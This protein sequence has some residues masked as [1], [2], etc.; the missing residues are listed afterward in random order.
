MTHCSGLGTSYEEAL[1]R[2]YAAADT[3]KASRTA[4]ERS[5]TIALEEAVGRV[6]ACDILSPTSTPEHDTSAMDGYAIRSDA[7]KGASHD[8]P[9]ILR[10]WGTIAAGDDPN[11]VLGGGDADSEQFASTVEPCLEIMTGARFPSRGV[12]KV[13]DACVRME[14]VVRIEGKTI[15]GWTVPTRGTYIAITKPVL[16]KAN[17]RI[18]GEDIRRHGLILK[19]G[20]TI[21]SSHLLP[22]A[23]VGL[24][25]LPV[26]PKPQVCV[27]STG[28][29]LGSGPVCIPDVNGLYLSAA[30]REHG[31][32]AGFLGVLQDDVDAVA[33]TIMRTA[34]NRAA[35]ILITSGGVSVGKF[36][37]IRKALDRIGADIIF[38]GLAIRPGHP[39]LFALI[40]SHRGKVAFF[41]LPG[42]PGAAAACFRFLVVPFLRNW[43]HS[44]PEQPTRAQLRPSSLTN[45]CRGQVNGHRHAVSQPDRDVFKPGLLRVT[46]DGEHICS[47]VSSR[48]G[49]SLLSPYIDANCWM[50][51]RRNQTP[52]DLLDCY[53]MSPE[54]A[55]QSPNSPGS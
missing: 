50:H 44:G 12:G 21:R 17:R 4:E 42:N 11:C 45:D 37:H 53:P 13:L 8:N 20:H 49:P 51:F 25:S 5:V 10:V 9:V 40:P 2:L 3:Q 22:L 27:W 15:A 39:V 52:G 34:D 19:A 26:Q 38:H 35:N 32:E 6:A 54:S 16:P 23:S 55:I 41:G 14:D 18:A 28:N 1:V 36:D 7:T 46:A 33:S 47:E 30:S 29:E 31:A 24:R 48:H 43:M